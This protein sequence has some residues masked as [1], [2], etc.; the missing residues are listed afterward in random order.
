MCVQERLWVYD[1][2]DAFVYVDEWARVRVICG[3]VRKSACVLRVRTCGFRVCTHVSVITG[4][5]VCVWCVCENMCMSW[6]VD[7]R[8][9]VRACPWV[10]VCAHMCVSVHVH[11]IYGVPRACVHMYTCDL[12]WIH[13]G[14]C[15]HACMR[16]WR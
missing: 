16:V 12:E 13:M 6:G 2:V 3:G 14:M 7:M 9:C 11:M 15:V 5:H 1:C 8:V 10:H 4:A